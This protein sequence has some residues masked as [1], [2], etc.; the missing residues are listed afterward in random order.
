MSQTL[1]LK[2]QKS[3]RY[4]TYKNSAHRSIYCVAGLTGG[5]LNP[6][7]TC[8]FSSPPGAAATR[9]PARQAEDEGGGGS[10]H[11]Q[12]LRQDQGPPARGK[13]SVNV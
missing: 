9:E 11:Q 8:A 13:K 10:A 3:C 2:Q 1:L 12:S 4:S 5:F 7:V 6:G